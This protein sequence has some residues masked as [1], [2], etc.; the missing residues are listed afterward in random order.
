MSFRALLDANVLVP[1]TVADLLLRCAELH[2]Y[3]PLWSDRITEETARTLEQLRPSISRDR[4][5][6]RIT[7]MEEDFP[8]DALGQIDLFAQSPDEFM[9]DLWDLKPSY[10]KR[11]AS[12]IGEMSEAQ[13]LTWR[14]TARRLRKAGLPTFADTIAEWHYDCQSD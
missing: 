1:I 8:Q 13:Q 6:K 12:I 3:E 14:D 2:F 7:D 11:I 5:D 4:I 9:L 10:P